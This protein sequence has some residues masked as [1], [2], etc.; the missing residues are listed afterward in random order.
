MLPFI[1]IRDAGIDTILLG[2]SR[3]CRIHTD[4]STLQ[5][6]AIFC[7]ILQHTVTCCNMLQHACASQIR[8]IE[9]DGSNTDGYCCD[10]QPRDET[11][12]M[13]DIYLCIYI[14]I[15]IYIFI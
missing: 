7:N 2:I 9:I 4:G 15:N 10:Y 12:L 5:Y 14:C 1:R 3:I 11:E 6:S 8:R 13:Y